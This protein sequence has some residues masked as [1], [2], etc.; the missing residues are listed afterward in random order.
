MEERNK[1]DFCAIDVENIGRISIQSALFL[2]K[3][4]HGEKISLQNW[5]QFLSER[6]NPFD[7]ISYDEM[8]LFLCNIPESR[9][10]NS[11]EEYTRQEMEL[12]K[13][14]NDT[15]LR[16]HQALK[17]LQVNFGVI[18]LLGFRGGIFVVLNNLFQKLRFLINDITNNCFCI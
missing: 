15:N 5:K 7:D 13:L 16:M 6:D 9:S 3:A 1:W 17:K 14:G 11:D 18:W 8:K 4:V 12:N 2:S 10:A